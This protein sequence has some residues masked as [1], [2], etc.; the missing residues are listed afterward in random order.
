MFDTS[1]LDNGEVV[2]KEVS[3]ADPVLTAGEVVTTADVEVNTIMI[4]EEVAKNLEAEMQAELEKEERLARQKEEETNIAL[5]KS[6]DNTQAMMDAYYELAVRL[7]EEERGELTIKEK[8]RLFVELMDKRKKHFARLRAKKIKIKPPTK[9]QQRN[10]M[11]NYLKNMAN[12][13]HS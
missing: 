11:C 7:Q 9:T 10:Q 12:Y 6:W 8:S 2:E 4:D 1:I 3:T 13:K 5:I